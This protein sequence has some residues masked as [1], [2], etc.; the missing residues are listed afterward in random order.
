MSTD[1]TTTD[2]TDQYVER[3]MDVL[4]QH[5][6]TQV[7]AAAA[8]GM[9]VSNFNQGMRRR[10]SRKVRQFICDLSGQPESYFW[11]P[12]K[13]RGPKPKNNTN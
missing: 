8:L 12:A 10:M 7:A 13:K 3:I 1:Q 2:E 5:K 9:H 6:L 4:A 11:P